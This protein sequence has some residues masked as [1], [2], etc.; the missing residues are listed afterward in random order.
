MTKIIYIAHQISG[1]I[2]ENIKS[3][4]SIQREI[5]TKNKDIVPI[6]PYLNSLQY[7]DDN[8]PEERELGILA[9]KLYF[10]K[11]F[12]D[13]TWIAGPKISFGMKEEI[14][15]S[16]GNNIPVECY[17][18]ALQPEIEK[19][20]QEYRPDKK[21]FMICPVRGITDEEAQFLQDYIVELESTGHKVHYPPRDTNQDDSI[22]LNIC[23]E[24]RQA[25]KDSDEVHIYYN[26]SSSGSKFDFGMT[27]MVEKP[28]VFVNKDTVK[29]TSH[30]SFQNVLHEIDR[31]YS[32]S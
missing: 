7:L 24:N 19:L 25:I 29:K 11:R 16:F 27:F 1:N 32:K 15:L 30:K 6:A 14:K 10:E 22:G 21:I 28:L 3:V 2:E 13:E 23:S 8:V 17:N 9:D 4:L 26:E 12:I 20:I 31:I 5:H 18:S